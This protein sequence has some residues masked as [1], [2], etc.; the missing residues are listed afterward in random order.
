MAN[1]KR[2]IS[3][4]RPETISQKGSMPMQGTFTR[5]DPQKD[6]PYKSGPG[7]PNKRVD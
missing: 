5:T 3:T 4:D 6:V 1:D 7:V 2:G